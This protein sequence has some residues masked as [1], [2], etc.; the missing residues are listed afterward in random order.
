MNFVVCV[1]GLF[2]FDK[3]HNVFNIGI[4]YTITLDLR[5]DYY[6]FPVLVL[7]INIFVMFEP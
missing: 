5:S 6:T 4:Y 7:V 3:H 1:K 2:Y